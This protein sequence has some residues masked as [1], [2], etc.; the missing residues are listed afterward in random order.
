M[1][2]GNGD[3]GVPVTWSILVRRRL[4]AKSGLHSLKNVHDR[5]KRRWGS[6]W[7]LGYSISPGALS[8]RRGLVKEEGR[9]EDEE[10]LDAGQAFRLHVSKR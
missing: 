2:D 10:Y 1:C 6:G 8:I 4:D 9:K 5:D 3:D 7:A